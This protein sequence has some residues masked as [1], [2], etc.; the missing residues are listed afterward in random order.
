MESGLQPECV[1]LASLSTG[2]GFREVFS[3]NR[4]H[5][6]PPSAFPS[7]SQHFWAYVGV[8][9]WGNPWVMLVV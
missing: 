7:C 6:K 3:Y 8:R 1:S 4:E 5:L 2:A 9:V